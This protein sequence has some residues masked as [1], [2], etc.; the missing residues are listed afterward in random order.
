[1]TGRAGRA[2]RVLASRMTGVARPGGRSRSA[3]SNE[4]DQ[5][6]ATVDR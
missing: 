1:M 3:A 4:I 2:S 5:V 6:A